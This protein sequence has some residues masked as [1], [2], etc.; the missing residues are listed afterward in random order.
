MNRVVIE[1]PLRG[2]RELNKLYARVC[3]LDCLIRGEAPY[4]SH[5]FFDHDDLLDDEV[6]Q[7]RELGILA[8]FAWGAAADLRVYYLDLGESAG[9]R[10]A[11]F[12][13]PDQ[14]IQDR[15]LFAR[16]QNGDRLAQ[17]RYEAWTAATEHRRT[18]GSAA[19]QY[20]FLKVIRAAYQ[21]KLK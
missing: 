11:R 4:A 3:A 5:L 2:D 18:T 1:S 14:P 9:M 16:D 12:A 21:E 10:R 13:F 15:R 17:R 19:N 20:V 7:Q 6:P 8:G